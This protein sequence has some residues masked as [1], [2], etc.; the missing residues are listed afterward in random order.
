MGIAGMPERRRRE[1]EPNNAGKYHHSNTVD[2]TKNT[3]R[4]MEPNA[5]KYHLYAKNGQH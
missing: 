1:T 2:L 3:H 5:G 4:E